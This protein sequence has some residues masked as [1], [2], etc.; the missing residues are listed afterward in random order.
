LALQRRKS[1]LQR[2]D[3]RIGLG[4][5]LGGEAAPVLAAGGATAG[6]AARLRGGGLLVNVSRGIAGAALDGHDPVA[7]MAAAASRWA[8]TL[9]C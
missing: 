3:L 8:A 5:P 7:A 4:L 9:E 6:P 2:L 1:L